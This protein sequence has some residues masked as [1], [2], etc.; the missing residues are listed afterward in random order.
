MA[1]SRVDQNRNA[2]S[3]WSGYIHQ[4]KVGFLV[5]LRHLRWCIENKIENFEDYAIRYENA[6]DFDIIDNDGGVIS[7]HQVK[8]YVNGKSREK[9]SPLF[10]IQKRDYGEF[11]DKNGNKVWKEYIS[12]EG[13]Q[14]HS[15]DGRGKIKS[16]DVNTD[17]RYIHVIVDVIDFKL[18]RHEYLKKMV[19]GK[20]I[21]IIIPVFNYIHIIEGK[22]FVIAHCHKTI[23]MIRLEII[24]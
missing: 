13:F 14:I 23:A 9:Y 17:S 12:E 6:E 8:A 19:A 5:A 2:T 16:V 21:L 4:G 18:S 24:V 22:T 15:F 10:N 1:S 7:R 3:S 20:T 11:I